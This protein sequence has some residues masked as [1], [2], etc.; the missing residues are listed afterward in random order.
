MAT[1]CALPTFGQLTIVDSLNIGH[2]ANLLDGL[3]VTIT[4]MAENCPP[5]VRGVRRQ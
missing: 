4:N 5:S 2:L 3:N 1:L